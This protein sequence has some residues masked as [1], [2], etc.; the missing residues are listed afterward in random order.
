MKYRFYLKRLGSEI[1]RR[2]KMK[3]ISQEDM[4][5]DCAIDRISLVNIELGKRNPT[6]KTL[7]KISRSLKIKLKDLIVL[8]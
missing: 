6:L 1:K 8:F 4:A 2:R 3:N 7:L 5:F